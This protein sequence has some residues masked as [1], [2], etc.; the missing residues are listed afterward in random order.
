MSYS[1]LRR[2]KET[3]LTNNLYD[4]DVSLVSEASPDLC[5]GDKVLKKHTG[6]HLSHMLDMQNPSL[7]P[8]TKS[9]LTCFEGK[10]TDKPSIQTCRI[11]SSSVLQSL[12]WNS[13]P[14]SGAKNVHLNTFAIR[15]RLLSQVI[16]E[17]NQQQTWISPHGSCRRLLHGL[18]DTVI[19]LLALET[20]VSYDFKLSYG[21]LFRIELVM[22]NLRSIFHP[23]HNHFGFRTEAE[24]DNLLKPPPIHNG[25]GN[26]AQND[27]V[28]KYLNVYQRVVTQKNE[29]KINKIYHP[30]NINAIKESNKEPFSN[31]YCVLFVN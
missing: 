10:F 21:Y 25:T 30:K 11:P 6:E 18:F 29:V 31:H 7:R 20:F 22:S 15:L 13:P 3:T 23:K 8:T 26:A 5:N 2:N 28:I 1:T 4:E 9:S 19:K 14:I 17:N 24:M 12:I 16:T 27:A